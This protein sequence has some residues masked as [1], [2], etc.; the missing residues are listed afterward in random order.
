M[1]LEMVGRI[2]L[3]RGTWK[4]VSLREKVLP[5]VDIPNRVVSF[6]RIRVIRYTILDVQF[7]QERRI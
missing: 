2:I 7:H 1:K 3:G 6:K 5:M 4:R